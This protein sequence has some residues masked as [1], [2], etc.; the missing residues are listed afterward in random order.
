M[1]IRDRDTSALK[2]LYIHQGF[3]CTSLLPA[4]HNLPT[5]LGIIRSLFVQH[6]YPK[7][8]NSHLFQLLTMSHNFT[9]KTVLTHNQNLTL[10]YVYFQTHPFTHPPNLSTNP[11]KLSS[12]SPHK[13]ILYRL[14][15]IHISEPTR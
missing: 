6:I 5:T 10:I 1:C 7:Y 8:L 3:N 11:L 2:S 9:P 12:D 14:S 4:I 13:T 15:L